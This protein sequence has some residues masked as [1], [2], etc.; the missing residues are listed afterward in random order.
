MPSLTS[1][2]HHPGVSSPSPDSPVRRLIT[3]K[4]GVKSVEHHPWESF[5]ILWD[6]VP[7]LVLYGNGNSDLS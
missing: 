4:W 7:M 6:R 5:T 2:S 1:A 3:K